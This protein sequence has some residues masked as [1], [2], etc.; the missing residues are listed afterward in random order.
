MTG[1]LNMDNQK[2]INLSDP[3]SDKDGINLKTL[4]THIIKP[5]DHTNRFAYV[6]NP[7]NG[8]LK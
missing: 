2:L 4:N 3:Q 6:M 8:L 7:K 1:S 5:S